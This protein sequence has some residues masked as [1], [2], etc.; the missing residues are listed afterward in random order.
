M[1]IK[2]IEEI[3]IYES[4]DG[5]KTVY[6][7]RGGDVNRTLMYEDPVAKRE[8]ELTRRWANLKEAVF[9]ADSDPT[10]ND[11]LE[12]LEIVYALKKKERK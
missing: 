12:K 3:T 11:A 7:R 8:T 9:M 4:P 5:G 2:S 6:S 10:I 1:I